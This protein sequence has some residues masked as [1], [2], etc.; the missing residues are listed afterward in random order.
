MDLSNTA[1]KKRICILND[2]GFWTDNRLKKEA[3]SLIRGGYQVTALA[4]RYSVVKHGAPATKETGKRFFWKGIEVIWIEGLPRTI[5]RKMFSG[6]YYTCKYLILYT[7]AAWRQKAD[8]YHAHNLDC[9]VPAYLSAKLRKAKV[10]Y[11]SREFFTEVRISQ[12][13][14]SRMMLACAKVLE[15]YLVR[16]S[17]AFIT[18]CELFGE[19][20]S[21]RYGVSRPTVVKNC[22][23]YR[24]FRPENILRE[25]LN[26]SDDHKV[27]LYLSSFFPGRGVETIISAADALPENITL[28]LLGPA[29]NESYMEHIRGLAQGNHRLR[30]L[31]PVPVDQ[32][33][34]VM[35]S[36][37]LGL[38]FYKSAFFANNSLSNKLFDY[39]MAGLPVVAVAMSETRR[40][41]NEVNFGVC[42]EDANPS[43]L[44]REMVTVLTDTER[45]SRFRKNALRYALSKY[46]WEKEEIKLLSVYQHL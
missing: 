18:V 8:I 17:D 3:R 9:L 23:P 14:F 40:I 46:S 5:P 33:Q 20:F 30:L 6:F 36:A 28:V 29:V 13:L 44:A 12:T 1:G 11:D 2:S 25:N 42:L 26:L 4:R 19:E 35:R 37:D 15:K 16:R 41:I 39:M 24:P 34:G 31:P 22:P 45:L 43:R 38:I 21:K 10:V 32:V 7:V 27:V